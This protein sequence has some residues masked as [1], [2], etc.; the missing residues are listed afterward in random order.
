M[1]VLSLWLPAHT[2]IHTSK[3]A[4]HWLRVA[5]DQGLQPED[6]PQGRRTRITVHVPAVLSGELQA[7]KQRA[8]HNGSMGAFTAGLVWAAWRQAHAAP[9]PSDT[10]AA[11][12]LPFSDRPEQQR[13]YQ[14]L[15]AGLERDRIVLAE[16]ATGLGKGRVIAALA[17]HY[18]SEGVVVAAPTLQIL[19]QLLEEYRMLHGDGGGARFL[20]G[21]D[22]F[23][24]ERRLQTWLATA[25]EEEADAVAAAT[26]WL[27]AGAG[28]VG[29][30]RTQPFH[31]H[32]PG[33]AFLA[34]DL[35]SVAPGAPLNEL[36][37]RA[38]DPEDGDRG[39]EAYWR[40]RELARQSHGTVIFATHA[41]LI[42][43]VMLRR[44]GHDGLLPDRATVLIDEGHL[45]AGAA[46]AAHGHAVA[47]RTLEAALSQ[48]EVWRAHRLLTKAR[49]AL[50][51]VRGIRDRITELSSRLQGASVGLDLHD[52]GL[53]L[54][55]PLMS[56][57]IDALRPLAKAPRTPETTPVLEAVQIAREIVRGESRVSVTFSPVRGYPSIRTGPYS[58]R[59]FFEDFWAQMR[60][61]GLIS[62]TLYLPR[63]MA[64]P[65]CALLR[66]SLHLPRER[67]HT[68]PPVRLRW[69]IDSVVLH[70]PADPVPFVPP[71]ESQ[72]RDEVTFEEWSARWHDRVA[73][74]VKVA[75]DSA[76]GGTLVLL[77]SYETANALEARLAAL[78]DR[79]I[80][81]RRGGFRLALAEY[82]EAYRQG[83]RP[84]W[85]A[86]G[87]AWTG[88][89][90][91]DSTSPA[92]HDFL[93]TDVIIPRIPF[94]MEQ[95]RTHRARMSWMQ[96]A[97]RDR[98]AFQFKQGVG[99]LVRRRGVTNRR[100]WVLDGRI[101][102]R[103]H[104]WLTQP[105]RDLL[106]EYRTVPVSFD[107]EA[108][109]QSLQV[110]ILPRLKSGDS[111]GAH[112]GIEPE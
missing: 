14:Q 95:S 78:K 88:L 20:F 61:A 58:L 49:V 59:R 66:A 73:A 4:K 12:T 72:S 21:R 48:A 60:R 41:G 63:R 16:G 38:E 42:R 34:E 92:E 22:Q 75:A 53:E 80:A 55:R 101:W 32:L 43:D 90:L 62:A 109:E 28:A 108:G 76:R 74:A 82:L 27:A 50:P 65:S 67:T 46:E 33:L 99:R 64:E 40:L 11:D 56:E 86:T 25:D 37:L 96:S 110:D 77:S 8:G 3:E 71:M 79:L 45:F 10:D 36:R 51:A 26:E 29:A 5:L 35:A 24:S 2:E 112:P 47:F 57:L 98:A 87:P 54:L 105:V 1:A 39:S 30:S 102:T 19:G 44:A 104:A 103:E 107:A 93:L 106:G 89:D 83:R 97:E 70:T 111:Y 23:I 17:E 52:E 31:A 91:S 68:F 9:A 84:V 15:L 100:L 85:L 94:G 6:I 69:L 7:A 13:F 81:Q 18:A